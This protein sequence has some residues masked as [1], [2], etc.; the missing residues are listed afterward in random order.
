MRTGQGELEN[1]RLRNKCLDD[2]NFLECDFW[3]GM[4]FG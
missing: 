1:Q 2:C 4:N 3:P